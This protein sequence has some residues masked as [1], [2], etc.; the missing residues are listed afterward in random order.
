M[1]HMW[2]GV[3]WGVLWC[4]V[5]VVLLH[6]SNYQVFLRALHKTPMYPIFWRPTGA[7][8]WG[9]L[10]SPQFSTPRIWITTYHIFNKAMVGSAPCP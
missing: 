10:L 4:V 9:T 8:N 6:V 1:C 3:L 2:W 7:E 5:L